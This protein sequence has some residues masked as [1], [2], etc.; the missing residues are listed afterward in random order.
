MVN[1]Q[2]GGAYANNGLAKGKPN[3][4]E[5]HQIAKKKGVTEDD[6]LG[7][8][9][10]SNHQRELDDDEDEDLDDGGG[11]DLEDDDDDYGDNDHL[12]DGNNEDLNHQ[13]RLEMM[14]QMKDTSN[15][16]SPGKGHQT[17]NKE[18]SGF[19]NFEDDTLNERSAIKKKKAD[20]KNDNN[21]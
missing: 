7:M 18:T 10:S 9:P 5:D 6:I 15:I 19:G 2:G 21:N 3:F 16:C 20:T 11:E 17:N 8:P 12:D 4:K 1:K 13:R 14:D